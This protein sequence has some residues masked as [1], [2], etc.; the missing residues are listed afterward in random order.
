MTDLPCA[1]TL[2]ECKA[3][4]Q[5]TLSRQERIANMQGRFQAIEALGLNR[6]LLLDDVIT[7]GA[8]LSS[9]QCALDRSR[10]STR[11]VTIAR[12]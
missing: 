10:C 4:D 9:A 1:Q 5:R 8:T 3:A 12:A 6:V 7:T 2:E 11:I